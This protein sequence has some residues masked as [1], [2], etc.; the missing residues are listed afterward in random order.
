MAKEQRPIN[1]HAIDPSLVAN[2][3]RNE[4]KPKNLDE[5]DHADKIESTKEF[6]DKF[7]DKVDP[8]GKNEKKVFKT[9]QIKFV[10]QDPSVAANMGK[11]KK[12]DLA[13]AQVKRGMAGYEE[14]G[15][16]DLEEIQEVHQEKYV[17]PDVDLP[18]QRQHHQR[19][20]AEQI[21]EVGTHP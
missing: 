9:K 13:A 21:E 15:H 16:D 6:Q 10:A 17:H 2:K 19:R 14:G 20:D 12:A 4:P 8:F 18:P 5:I 11:A 3:Q 1:F 7:V